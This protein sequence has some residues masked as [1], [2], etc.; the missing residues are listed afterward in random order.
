M[1]GMEGCGN[2]WGCVYRK[3]IGI[4]VNALTLLALGGAQPGPRSGRRAPTQK[5]PRK[6]LKKHVSRPELGALVVAAAVLSLVIA[7][8]AH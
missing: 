8:A 7:I 1:L 5:G 2:I 4:R 6:S 3:N